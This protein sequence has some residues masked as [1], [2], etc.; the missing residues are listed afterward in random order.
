MFSSTKNRRLD[1]IY[2]DISPV[3]SFLGIYLIQEH[4]LYYKKSDICH[5]YSDAS[6]IPPF[7]K[8]FILFTFCVFYWY[9][10]YF[11]VRFQPVEMILAHI[12]FIFL[13]SWL[14]SLWPSL[15]KKKQQPSI[16]RHSSNHLTVLPHL[17]KHGCYYLSALCFVSSLK[18]DWWDH[19]S[20]TERQLFLY[21]MLTQYFL[22]IPFIDTWT[23]SILNATKAI[24]KLSLMWF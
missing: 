5:V 18:L 3:F 4:S 7:R 21:V 8:P 10:F 17:L 6:F 24:V 1:W 9:T 15:A 22:E 16:Y 19:A 2:A 11:S 23:P 12:Q 14:S 20:G 13:F